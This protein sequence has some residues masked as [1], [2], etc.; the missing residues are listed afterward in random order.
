MALESAIKVIFCPPGHPQQPS[1]A[2]LSLDATYCRWLTAC[3]QLEGHG[4]V[5]LTVKHTASRS[6]VGLQ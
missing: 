6:T 5:Y 2:G 4:W 3:T 1:C